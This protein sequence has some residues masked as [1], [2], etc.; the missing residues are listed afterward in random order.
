M[1]AKAAAPAPKKAGA[2]SKKV[3]TANPLFVA[4]PRSF[5][6]GG[7]V[8]PKGRDLSRFVRWPKYVRVQRQKK[9]LLQRLKMPPSLH[10]FNRT[11]DKNQAAELFKLLIKY[12]PET[13]EAKL[14]RLESTAAAVAGKTASATS[15]P[16]ATLK[17]GLKHVTSLIEK[18]KAKLVVIAHD[19]D[20]IELVLW[21][22]ALCRKMDV[23]FAIVKGKARLG[24]LTHLKTASVVALTKVNKDDEAKLKQLTESFHG[25]FNENVE[26]KWRDGIMGLK[27]QA[28]LEKRREQ[29]EAERLKKMEAQR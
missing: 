20:P 12:Q 1:P 6:I 16:A 27:T 24:T 22:P 10:Q 25:Q 4:R 13:K 26:R 9:I 14:K 7:D 3:R 21:L 23:P 5:R 29:V 2:K 15:E 8:R 11:L 19:V 18:K 28:K 17:F